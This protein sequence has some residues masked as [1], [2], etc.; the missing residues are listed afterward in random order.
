MSWIARFWGRGQPA[1]RES[2]DQTASAVQIARAAR[3]RM[4]DHT[5]ER[6][7]DVARTR[8]E[9]T[10]VRRAIRTGNPIED[11]IFPLPDAPARE[12]RQ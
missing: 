6:R 5:T 9:Q 7:R 10:R 11:T 1:E 12:K 3:A 4:E 8:L 2:E